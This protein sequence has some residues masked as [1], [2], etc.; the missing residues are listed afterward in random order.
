MYEKIVTYEGPSQLSKTESVVSNMI[1]S[2]INV[3][4]KFISD[5]LTSH[6]ISLKHANFYFKI[7]DSNELVLVFANNFKVEPLVRIA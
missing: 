6:G 4:C 7:D 3:A 2:D 5:Q 1:L